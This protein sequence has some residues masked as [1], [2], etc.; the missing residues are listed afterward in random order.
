MTVM[1]REAELEHQYIILGLESAWDGGGPNPLSHG[2][3]PPTP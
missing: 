2:F 3:E 1:S